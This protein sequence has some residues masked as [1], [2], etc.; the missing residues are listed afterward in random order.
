MREIIDR[1]SEQEG[2]NSSRLPSF[3]AEW[4]NTIN[5]TFE[6]KLKLYATHT[7]IVY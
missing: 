2:R 7:W 5:G 6:F 3:D 1:K 4:T